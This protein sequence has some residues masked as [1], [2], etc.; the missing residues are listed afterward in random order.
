MDEQFPPSRIP[1]IPDDKASDQV[2][3]MWRMFNRMFTGRDDVA[4]VNSLRVW[5]HSPEMMKWFLPFN[6]MVQSEGNGRAL[7][8]R[9]KQLA[10]VRTSQINGC[11]Y[12]LRHNRAL[13]R[14]TGLGQEHF[15]AM[16]GDYLA[17]DL[18]TDKEK[19]VIRW[20]ELV[21]NNTA[22]YD[23]EA[24]QDLK[25]HLTDQEVVEL[26]AVSAIFAMNNRFMDSLHIPPD[27]EKAAKK[28]A[29]S[30]SQADEYAKAVAGVPV[31]S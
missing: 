29:A 25:S 16:E 5:A 21:T 3:T 14:E 28:F 4:V 1:L 13:G 19:S 20:A 7:D 18:F 2:L 6:A 10:V 17:N 22:R 27:E 26:T 8:G 9:L 11:V 23:D 24:F 15:D 30:T 12:C 31:E